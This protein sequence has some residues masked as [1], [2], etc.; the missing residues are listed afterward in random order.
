MVSGC[1]LLESWHLINTL[2]RSHPRRVLKPSGRVLII[3]FGPPEPQQKS[4]IDHFHH[5]GHASLPSLIEL[6][7]RSGM[8]VAESG[9]VG[10]SNLNYLYAVAR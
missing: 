1:R 9:A 2:T 4:I 6:V 3:D 8:E 7:Q 5:H 10:I